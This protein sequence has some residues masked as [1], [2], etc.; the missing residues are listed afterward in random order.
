VGLLFLIPG[1]GETLRINGRAAIVTD[2]ALCESF[3]V[4]GK[5]PR[6]VIV[7]T[8]DSVYFQCGKAIIRSRL[9]HADAQIER[10]SLP[11]AG[12]ILAAMSE[13]RMGG[14]AY[15]DAYPERLKQTLY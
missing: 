3:T 1:I 6:S 12:E 5:A 13:N 4:E 14:Q 2:A 8:V 15:D 10:K 11:S 7:I 9:W